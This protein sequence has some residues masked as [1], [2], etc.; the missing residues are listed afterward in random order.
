MLKQIHVAEKK[1]IQ[2]EIVHA[3][4]VENY[5]YGKNRIEADIRELPL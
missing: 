1:K 2:N 5:K 4:K 3:A